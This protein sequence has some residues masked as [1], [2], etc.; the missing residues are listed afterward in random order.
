MNVDKT[1]LVRLRKETLA[2]FSACS[3]A[4]LEANNDYAEAKKLLFKS[5]ILKAK[6]DSLAFDDQL[7][8]GKIYTASF[9]DN[10]L[11]IL[12]V[13]RAQTDFV[14]NSKDFESTQ[15]EVGKILLDYFKD[16]EAKEQ[17]EISELLKIKSPTEEITIEDKILSL[18]SITKE[19]IQLSEVWVSPQRENYITI[20]YKHHNSKLGAVMTFEYQQKPTDMDELKKL[21]LHYSASECKFLREEEAT[22]VWI[23]EEKSKLKEALLAKNPNVPNVDVILDKQIKKIVSEVSFSSQSFILDQSLKI[24]SILTKHSLSPVWA[25]K[26]ST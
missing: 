17:P 23:E 5:S 18:A 1:L 16:K 24:S 10:S 4:L 20:A 12:C 14:T 25:K 21:V 11:G 8:E 13:W 9:E 22:Q 7:P 2:P 3:K 6:S 19:K 15:I 26:L